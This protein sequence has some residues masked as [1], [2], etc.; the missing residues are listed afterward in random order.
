MSFGDIK[1]IGALSELQNKAKGVLKGSISEKDKDY[2]LGELRKEWELHLPG[3]NFNVEKQA[4]L[5]EKRIKRSGLKFMF[6]QA[7]ITREDL[8]RTLESIKNVGN[9]S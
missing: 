5:A 9:K 1:K 7:G 2:F 4:D 3:T 8:I 6:D